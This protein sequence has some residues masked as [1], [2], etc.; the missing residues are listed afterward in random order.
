MDDNFEQISRAAGDQLKQT[1]RSLALD[2]TAGAQR[3][4]AERLVHYFSSGFGNSPSM[5]VGGLLIP[6]TLRPTTDAD[7]RVVRRYSESEIHNAMVI[8]G[9]LLRAE[10]IDIRKVKVRQLD[11]GT[12]APVT[13]I[14]VEAFYG[15][16]RGNTQMDLATAVGPEA[17]PH[18]DDVVWTT[19]PSIMKT[20]P[21]YRARAQPMETA[22]AEKW[23]AVL[24]KEP[25]DLR[26]KHEADLVLFGAQGY[27]IHRI[28]SEL[29]RVARNRGMDEAAVERLPRSLS[30]PE[31]SRRE[32]SWTAEAAKR[33]LSM[34]V[35]LAFQ[36]L[37][38]LTQE[39]RAALE[40]GRKQELLRQFRRRRCDRPAAPADFG[41][42]EPIFADN[43]VAFRPR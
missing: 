29:R 18:T 6:Q 22:V 31:M 42:P 17:F 30:W 38:A 25:S 32:Q 15:G 12:G 28:A 27:D 16:I 37:N 13:R 39:L 34:S 33:R 21:G 4:V 26:M 8:I 2:V 40:F 11:V 9:G 3:S 1:C 24:T 35:D 5:L 43:V 41:R 20:G 7:L 36:E 19:F 23:L 14:A 10:G